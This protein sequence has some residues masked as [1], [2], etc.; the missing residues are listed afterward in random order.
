MPATKTDWDTTLH[1]SR[2]LQGPAPHQ[3]GPSF[4]TLAEAGDHG[5]MSTIRG[6]W[7]PSSKLKLVAIRA[8][9]ST[10]TARGA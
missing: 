9:P 6:I 7:D 2:W 4:H 3:A 5:A 1:L 10:A 8:L